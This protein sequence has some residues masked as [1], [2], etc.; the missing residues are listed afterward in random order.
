MVIVRDLFKHNASFRVGS[1][2]LL[3]I[4]LVATLSFVSPYEANKRRVV[5]KNYPPSQEYILGTNS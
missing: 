2:F 1:I 4:I 5:P 3:I